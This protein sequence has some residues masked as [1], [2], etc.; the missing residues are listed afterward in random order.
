MVYLHKGKYYKK[1]SVFPKG[2]NFEF[3]STP[4]FPEI[5]QV[6]SGLI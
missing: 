6:C 3:P 5:I 2:Y 1:P 4:S